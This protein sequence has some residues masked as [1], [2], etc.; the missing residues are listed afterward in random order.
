MLNF[1]DIVGQDAVLSRLQRNLAA[2]R[3]HHGFLFSGMRGIG[4]RT[5]A[6]ALAKL[7]LCENRQIAPN[8]GRVSYLTDDELLELPCDECESCTLMEAGTHTDY[9]YVYKELAQYHDDADVR[10]RKMQM[11]S[12]PVVKQFLL[13]PADRAP[14]RGVGKVFVIREAELMSLDA[15]NAFLKT[16]EEP[17]PGVTMILLTQKAEN[18]LPTTRSRCSAF[19]FAPLPEPFVISKLLDGEIPGREATFWARYTGGSIGLGL[20]MSAA[21]MYEIKCGMIEDLAALGAGRSGFGDAWAKTTDVLAEAE[22]SRAKKE[23]GANLSKAVAS[24]RAASGM[25]LL[26][27]SAHLD[28]ITMATG[29]DRPLVHD[30]QKAEISSIAGR[31]SQTQLAEIIEQLSRYEQLLWRNVSAKI[32]WENVALTCQSAAPLI[33]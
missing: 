9:H 33:L 28:A 14:S 10:Q 22:V 6:E 18:L 17:P 11:L 21:G 25:L 8:A 30:D 15:Q 29:M 3:L 2:E 24:R 26:L 27:A 19:R 13:D 7:L 31:L 23:S 32:V 20:E 16:L 4:R 12:L 1:I 5:T